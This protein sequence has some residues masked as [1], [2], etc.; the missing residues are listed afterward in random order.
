MRKNGNYGVGTMHHI[1]IS[2]IYRAIHQTVHE[3]TLQG[4]H[5]C[6]TKYIGRDHQ[7]HFIRTSQY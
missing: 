1:I 4:M 5:Q 2:E 6:I 3:D 7:P